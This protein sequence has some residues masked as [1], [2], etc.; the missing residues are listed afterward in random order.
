[1][2]FCYF[3]AVIGM[4]NECG[5]FIT[6]ALFHEAVHHLCFREIAHLPYPQGSFRIVIKLWNCHC[7]WIVEG[8]RCV[9]HYLCFQ[10]CINTI[11]NSSVVST[12]GPWLK[13][14]R[15]KGPW[16]EDLTRPWSIAFY[17]TLA[18]NPWPTV[19]DLFIVAISLHL[20]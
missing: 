3:H 14:P 11:P 4:K 12:P 18:L 6:L 2:I 13:A 19:T 8:G 15:C 9:P 20:I 5:I 1:M 10:N 7:P 16:E 17:S